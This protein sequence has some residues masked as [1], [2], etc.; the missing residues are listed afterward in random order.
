MVMVL[1]NDSPFGPTTGQ[2]HSELNLNFT[3]SFFD[4]LGCRKLL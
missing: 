2:I 1:E 4:L 3:E